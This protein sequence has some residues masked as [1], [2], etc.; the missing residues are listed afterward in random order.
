MD[1]TVNLTSLTSV[2]RIHPCPPR[3]T[4]ALCKG[5]S[6]WEEMAERNPIFDIPNDSHRAHSG[7]L[8]FVKDPLKKRHF[9]LRQR[10]Y[11]KDG[12]LFAII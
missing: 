1:Q 12:S 10:F 5:F 6:W 9:D 4:L 11:L 8:V 3:K 7:T 2:V